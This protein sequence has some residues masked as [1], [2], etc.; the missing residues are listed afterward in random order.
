MTR[1]IRRRRALVATLIL[2]ATLTLPLGT[3]SALPRGDGSEL[4][5]VTGTMDTVCRVDWRQGPRKVK[6]LIRCAAG[7]YHVNIDKALYV[8]RRESRFD[9]KAYNASSCAKGLFQHLCRYWPD[10]AD[11]Y[12]FDNWSAFNGR[13]NAFV[14]MRMVKRYGWDPWGL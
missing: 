7:Y 13:A 14:T 4:R 5:A 6:K 3:A 9:P 12:G 10:R 8:A 1:A 2:T 11:T